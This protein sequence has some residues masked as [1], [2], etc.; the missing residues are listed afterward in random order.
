MRAIE[1][2]NCA[3]LGSFTDRSPGLFALVEFRKIPPPKLRP[4]L[5]IMFEPLAQFGARPG[6]FEPCLNVQRFFFHS[7]RPES[8]NQITHSVGWSLLFIDAFELDHSLKPRFHPAIWA[9]RRG[10]PAHAPEASRTGSPPTAV[11]TTLSGP[12]RVN[13]AATLRS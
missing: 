3:P 11:S 13:S 12:A 8:L 4:F 5:R 7:T 9:P 10:R 1:Q 6:F 2:G